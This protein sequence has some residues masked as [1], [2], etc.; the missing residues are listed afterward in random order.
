MIPMHY[1]TFRL[2]YEPMDEPLTRLLAAAR[3]AGLANRIAPLT[4]G[5]TWFPTGSTTVQRPQATTTATQNIR[6]PIKTSN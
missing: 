3:Q 4:E 5:E 2:S 6:R 1:N